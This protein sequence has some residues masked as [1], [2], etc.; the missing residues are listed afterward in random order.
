MA[1][2]TGYS[3]KLSLQFPAEVCQEEEPRTKWIYRSCIDTLLCC[4]FQSYHLDNR[5]NN[6]NIA[7]CIL[8]CP[9]V[10][11]LTV[12][13]FFILALAGVSNSLYSFLTLLPFISV[14]ESIIAVCIICAASWTEAIRSCPQTGQVATLAASP[15]LLLHRWGKRAFS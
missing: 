10:G 9:L 4:Q 11:R 12:L 14:A 8:R 15:V 5:H 1:F 7:H 6:C 3:A 13:C 2:E